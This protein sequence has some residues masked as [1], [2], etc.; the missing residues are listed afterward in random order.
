MGRKDW[1]DISININQR[2]LK[3]AANA[4]KMGHKCSMKMGHIKWG[5]V[6]KSG[7][8]PKKPMENVGKSSAKG[9]LTIY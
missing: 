5:S 8:L 9:V 3:K 7:L 2:P 1:A 6:L 4:V